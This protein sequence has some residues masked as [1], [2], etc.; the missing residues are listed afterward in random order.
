[1]LRD[2]IT[3]ANDNFTEIVPFPLVADDVRA[4]RIV[5]STVCDL[6]DCVFII[7]AIR[8]D[9]TVVADTGTV[10][11]STAYYVI[12]NNMYSIEGE[13][14]FRLTVQSADGSALTSKEIIC[15]VVAANGE[16]GI[17][18]DDNYPVLTTLIS[19]TTALYDTFGNF[20]TENNTL[21]GGYIESG[22][23]SKAK[24]SEEFLTEFNNK[25]EIADVPTKTSELTNDSNFVAATN[26]KIDSGILDGVLIAEK[27]ITN[28]DA[29]N[30]Y[31]SPGIYKINYTNEDGEAY[32]IILRVNTW[33]DF[34][35]T[36]YV[37][38]RCHKSLNYSGAPASEELSRTITISTGGGRTMTAWVLPA[39][40]QSYVA[41]LGN[42]I[43]N[44][45][46]GELAAKADKNNLIS[47]QTFEASWQTFTIA[48]DSVTGI[49]TTSAAHGFA[50]NDPV[51][52]Q[53]ASGTLPA[54][55]LTYNSDNIGGTYY[56]IRTVADSTHF[57]ITDTVGGTTDYKPTTA[58]IIGYQIRLAGINTLT[59]SGLNL[60]NDNR[61]KIDISD[62]GFAKKTTAMSATYWR[63][64]N[65][66]TYKY[67]NPLTSYQSTAINLGDT[68]TR[69]Y[70]ILQLSMIIT[71]MSANTILIESNVNGVDSNDKALSSIIKSVSGTTV[72]EVSS[73][74]TTITVASNNT[75]VISIRNGIR[76]RVWRL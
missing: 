52:F 14:R 68:I 26:G 48:Y 36:V 45:L 25:I 54:G 58:G 13:T 35:G 24:L 2:I 65:S 37:Y 40:G 29:L 69:K 18:A 76:V 41:N 31:V 16:G 28:I 71:K 70:S 30:D 6:A 12:K 64:N 9:G 59:I 43:N 53:A 8:S 21:D 34:D 50:V 1:M 63:L 17:E 39:Y 15:E 56:N 60:D 23:V 49:F 55:L 38:Q 42:Y 46:P 11:G 22:T 19:K 33:T 20:V 10:T 74:V 4:Y 27:T 3:K 57:T 75:S 51:E 7:N 62:Y 66:A 67:I 73:N 72:K 44:T 47:D 5:F 61:Y 32:G